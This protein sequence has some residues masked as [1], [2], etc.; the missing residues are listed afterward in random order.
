M[1]TLKGGSRSIRDTEVQTGTG[2][3]WSEW[4]AVLDEVNA[5]EMQVIEITEHLVDAHEV[6]RVWAQVIAVYY[7]WGV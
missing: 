3:G 4:Q 1:S 5:K 7:K 2:R 6:E